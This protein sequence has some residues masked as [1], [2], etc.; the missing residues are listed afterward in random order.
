MEK[1]KPKVIFLPKAENSIFQI[2]IYIE[3]KGYPERAKRFADKLYDFGYSLATMPFG[4]PICRHKQL[5]KRKMH[6]A[7]FKKNYIFVYKVVK[8]KL[9]IYNVIHAMTNPAHFSA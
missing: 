6:C 1:E 9:Y 4:H 8:N 7:V 5:A 2:R 3:Q